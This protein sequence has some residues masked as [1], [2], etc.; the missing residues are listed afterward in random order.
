MVTVKAIIQHD[1]YTTR[2][3]AGTHE[4]LADEPADLSGQ[5]KGS[6][7][8]EFLACSLAACT[9]IT[10]RM[11]ADRKQWDI[12]QIEVEITVESAKDGKSTTIKR[13]IYFTGT[14]DEAQ[15]MRLLEIADRC[16][17]HQVLTNPID[18]QT[19]IV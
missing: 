1:H 11:Y 5:D 18:I 15:R 10:L 13:T 7:P 4:M 2:L 12:Q 3:V 19:T 8:S 9:A 14:L 17:M 6:R 16:P